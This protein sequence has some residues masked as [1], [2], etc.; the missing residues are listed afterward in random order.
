MTSHHKIWTNI[1]A[2]ISN[3]ANA[4]NS[5]AQVWFDSWCRLPKVRGYPPAAEDFAIDRNSLAASELMVLYAQGKNF[6]YK[7]YGSAIKHRPTHDMTGHR[8]SEFSSAGDKLLATCYAE[9][10]HKQQPVYLEQYADEQHRVPISQTLVLPLLD[11]RGRLWLVVHQSAPDD[12]QRRT[13]ANSPAISHSHT[14]DIAARQ[15]NRALQTVIET[16]PS[17]LG[18]FDK[19]LFLVSYNQRFVDMLGYPPSLFEQPTVHFEDLLRNSAAR[20]E[21]GQQDPAVA[22]A[23]VLEQSFK[24]PKQR[25]E[26]VRRDGR[27]LEIQGALMPDGGFMRTYTDITARRQADAKIRASEEQLQ[28]ALAASRLSLWDLD[29]KML[30]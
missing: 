24:Y 10:K 28:R 8:A 2:A 7:H 21:Y 22:I 5:A 9:V 27:I 1:A 25:V 17:G 4:D 18:V 23:M 20:G 26:Q 16:I 19:N 12:G 29:Q 3:I 6:F 13:K 11:T 14:I 15:S 30:S